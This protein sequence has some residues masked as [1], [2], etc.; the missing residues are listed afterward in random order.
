[1]AGYRDTA[2]NSI[3]RGNKGTTS[4]GGACLASVKYAFGM[5]YMEVECSFDQEYTTFVAPDEY[6]DAKK[7]TAVATFGVGI[8]K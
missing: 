6:S 5:R 4:W 3:D 8:R 1:M 7:S 2:V